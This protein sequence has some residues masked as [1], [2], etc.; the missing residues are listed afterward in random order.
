M[1]TRLHASP[2][3]HIATLVHKQDKSTSHLASMQICCIHDVL[4]FHWCMGTC[5]FETM[6]MTTITLMSL[7]I[8]RRLNEYTYMMLYRKYEFET[9]L[10]NYFIWIISTY[11]IKKTVATHGHPTSITFMWIVC[12]LSAL[13]ID[14]QLHPFSTVYTQRS[15]QSPLTW[16]HR[17]ERT[18]DQRPVVSLEA[19]MWNQTARS[20]DGNGDPIPDS[21]W[22][23]PLLGDGDGKISSPT[24]M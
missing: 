16:A 22:G 1:L 12:A 8:S 2:Y 13:T 5:V 7:K 14:D 10:N 21:P 24:G 23:I 18:L 19:N 6:P 9:C 11:V 15:H 4:L 3:V 20:R 17:L